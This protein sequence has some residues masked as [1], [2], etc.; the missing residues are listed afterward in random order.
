MNHAVG[1]AAES[2]HV[3][4]NGFVQTTILDPQHV[5]RGR[6][7]EVNGHAI[8][9]E[10]QH[11]LHRAVCALYHIACHP[12]RDGGQPLRQHDQF[13]ARVSAFFQREPC[14]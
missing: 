2:R 12:F 11:L 13:I 9:A 10:I 8:R 14:E 7:M 5:A 1:H 6:G 3:E 4:V